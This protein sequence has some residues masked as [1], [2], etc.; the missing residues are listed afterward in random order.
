MNCVWNRCRSR[1]DFGR[2]AV[3]GLA[4][5]GTLSLA[6]CESLNQAFNP[7]PKLADQDITDAYIYLLG[8][9]LVVRQEQRDLG[10]DFKWNQVIHRVPGDLSRP[11]PNLDV[12]YSEAWIAVDSASCTLVTVPSIKDRYYTIQMLNGW[13]ET[14]ANINERTFP[15]HPAGQF[16]LCLK[17]AN[18]LLES[19]VQRIDLPSRKS[20]VLM[21]VELGADPTQAVKLQRKITLI[22]TGTPAI[23]PTFDQPSF[24][25]DSLPG[26]EA[27]DRAEALLASEPDINPGME[28]IQAKLHEVVAAA[29]D[30]K[31]RAHVDQ[32]I[33][34]Q[35]VPQFH[36]DLQKLGT[37]R[38]GWDR[39]STMGNYGS[40]YV[41][42]SAVD[43]AG[44]WANNAGEV[45]FFKTNTDGEGTPLDG[46][47]AY[48]MTFPKDQLP[49]SLA[50]YFW[51]VTAVDSANFQVIENSLKRYRLNNQPKYKLNADGSLTLVFA[52][53]RPSAV[54]KSNWLPTPDGQNYYLTFRFYGPGQAITAGEYF[55]P[56]LVKME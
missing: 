10:S 34:E 18:V 1:R 33:R 42:R 15:E 17:G 19:S 32:V 55:P 12:A 44:I 43:F 3:L 35:S 11:N 28:G 26:V 54:A 21:R 48:S 16:A 6:A 8:R 27:F 7:P 2:L 51:S 39:W 46:D 5:A 52:S 20:R 50:H 41:A 24:S 29:A 23:E 38:D 14:T 49:G 45:A 30:P 40:D 22:A 4:L 25:D 9:M 36:A 13:G 31:Q 47:Q 37:S 56:P 53:K